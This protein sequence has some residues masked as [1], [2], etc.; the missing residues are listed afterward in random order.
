MS[1]CAWCGA[2]DALLWDRYAGC[3][4]LHCHDAMEARDDERAA[5]VAWLRAD[6]QQAIWPRAA[7]EAIE[8]G[9]HRK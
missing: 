1:K 8:R 2:S 6:H 3:C 7:A 5:I 9:D 4:S